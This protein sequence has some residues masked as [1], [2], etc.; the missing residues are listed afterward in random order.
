MCNPARTDA[1]STAAESSARA[2]TIFHAA[3]APLFATLGNLA[4]IERE[5]RSG[6]PASQ[7]ELLEAV[8]DAKAG[9][10]AVTAAF[11]ELRELLAGGPGLPK[12]RD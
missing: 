9:A 4:F 6:E 11:V 7:S 8:Q 1:G 2:E 3:A 5:M 10:R 12:R